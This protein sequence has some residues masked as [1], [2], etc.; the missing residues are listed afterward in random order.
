MD[1][2]HI[3]RACQ[4]YFVQLCITCLPSKKRKDISPKKVF[5]QNESK[6]GFSTYGSLDP[7]KQN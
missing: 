7:Q 5:F 4:G 2:Q 6:F 3:L 1:Q